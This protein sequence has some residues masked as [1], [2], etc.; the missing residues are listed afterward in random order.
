MGGNREREPG[1]LIGRKRY[2]AGAAVFVLQHTQCLGT[3][4][5]I[6]DTSTPDG[7]AQVECNTC[8]RDDVFIDIKTT[9]EQ[10]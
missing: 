1:I 3:R 4:G 2:E 6:I 7:S 10:G 9:A 5:T 8:G